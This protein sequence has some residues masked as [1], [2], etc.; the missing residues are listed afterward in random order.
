[1]GQDIMAE[2]LMESLKRQMANNDFSP[3]E[4]KMM[5]GMEHNPQDRFVRKVGGH[6]RLNVFRL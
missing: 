2:S 5:K 4:L 6:A 3:F 1:M